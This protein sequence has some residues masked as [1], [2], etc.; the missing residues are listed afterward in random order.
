MKKLQTT[1]MI[2]VLALVALTLNSCIEDEPYLWNIT[3]TWQL[4][5]NQYGVVGDYQ[6][7]KYN[8]NPDGT[9]GYG[10]FDNRGQ[11][12]SEPI[13]WRDGVL[14]INTL[15]VTYQDGTYDIYYYRMDGSGNLIL[16]DT[17]QFYKWE[18]FIPTTM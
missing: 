1:M 8:F 3:G 11:W 2:C 14:G 10:Y 13:L 15:Q 18:L 17:P 9:G 7:V 4:E 6:V 5:Q 16:S 12:G